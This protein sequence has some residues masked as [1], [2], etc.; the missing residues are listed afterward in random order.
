MK[1]CHT[2]KEIKCFIRRS[3]VDE[4]VHGLK[5]IGVKAMSITSV[6]GVGA[7]VD[8][9][10][11]ELSLDYITTYSRIYKIEV[12]CRAED[13]DLIVATIQRLAHTGER[14]DGAIFVSTVDRAV[15]IRS[16][17]EGCFILDKVSKQNNS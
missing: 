16:G 11:G 13:V 10:H 2:M 8:P 5:A 1:E 17:E 9:A 4:V 15:K 12:V 7:F 6:E 14:G 3:R